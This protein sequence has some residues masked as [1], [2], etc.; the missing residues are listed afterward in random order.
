MDTT[1]LIVGLIMIGLGFLVKFFP[2]LIS[3]YNTMTNAQKENVDIERLSTY[4][5]NGFIAMGLVIILGYYTFTWMGFT[6]ITNYLIPAVILVGV[7]YMVMGAQRFDHNKDKDLR[8][9]LKNVLVGFILVFAFGGIGYGLIPAKAHFTDN[10]VEFSGMYGT[11]IYFA[12]IEGVQLIGK[13]PAIR[14]RTNG[15][16]LG[17]VKKGFFNVDGFGNSRL[18]IHSNQGPYLIISKTDD[19]KTIMNFKDGADTERTF[20]R[21]NALV[22]N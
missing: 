11:E 8:S 14:G 18:L 21:I 7:I 6:L 13:R 3:G 5:R 1:A 19:K 2:N 10:S 17:S 12:E 16:S 15:L 22:E 20:Q 4:M 9:K